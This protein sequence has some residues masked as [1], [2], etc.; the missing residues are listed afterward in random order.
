MVI[1]RMLRKAITP[2]PSLKRFMVIVKLRATA[3]M[4]VNTNVQWTFRLRAGLGDDS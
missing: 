4:I 3:V 1:A 2:V